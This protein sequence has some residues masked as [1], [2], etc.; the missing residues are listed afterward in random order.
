[1]THLS[2]SAQD[3]DELHLKYY[4]D[5]GLAIAGLVLHHKIDPL[6]FNRKVDDALPLDDVITPDPQLRKLLSDIDRSNVKP[7][8]FTNAHITHGQRVVRLLGVQDMFE[9]ITFCDYSKRPFICKP[10]PEM[11]QKAEQEAGV[12]SVTDCYFV[13]MFLLLFFSNFIQL[14]PHSPLGADDSYLNCTHAHS[15]GWTAAHLLEPEDSDSPIP[16]GKYQIRSLNELRDLFPHFF[17]SS[18]SSSSQTGAQ[19]EAE[20]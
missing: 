16:A 13:G 4:K 3:A 18:S 10:H 5:Y 9:G 12:Q 19:V 6:E 2:L 17:I 7:W 8:L 15:R 14:T 20:K 1:M 11:F